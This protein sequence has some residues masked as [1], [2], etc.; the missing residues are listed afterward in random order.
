MKCRALLAL[1]LSAAS[2]ASRDFHPTAEV[3]VCHR[4]IGSGLKAD[5]LTY[6]VLV[7][8][9]VSRE[10]KV[11]LNYE[12]KKANSGMKSVFARFSSQ[13][14]SDGDVDADLHM[15]MDDS[16]V[17][18]DIS[19]NRNGNKILAVVNSNADRVVERV[20]LSDDAFK[21][22]Y[23]T[24]SKCVDLEA[25][26]DLDKH[27]QLVVKTSQ[28]EG[29]A[30]IELK[31]HLDA[32]NS[33]KVSVQPG[34]DKLGATVEVSR[35]LDNDSTLEPRFDIRS[36]Q[37]TCAWVRRRAGRTTKVNVDL[38][39]TVDIEVQSYDKADWSGK[40]SAPWGNFGDA[41]IKLWRQFSF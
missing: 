8:S 20:E 30:D 35:R 36:N 14:I 19:Y 34:T 39:K 18:G 33:I 32:D 37:L 40:I 13:K 5:D 21:I 6:E 2:A 31:H 12:H 7:E 28:G 16:Q 10:L 25:S 24:D 22:T 26:G 41:D 17:A 27:T 23:H 9:K 38:D 1:T 4:N 29:T 3:S 11:G 15:S